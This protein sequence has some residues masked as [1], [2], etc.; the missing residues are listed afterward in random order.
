M[1]KP[2]NKVSI[3]LLLA[4]IVLLCVE[5][6]LGWIKYHNFQDGVEGF[7]PVLDVAAS[8][9][10]RA[11]WLGGLAALIEILDQIRWHLKCRDAA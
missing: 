8:A 10:W 7:G 6:Y 1:K 3:V 5:A 4:L 11:A 9:V 2:F